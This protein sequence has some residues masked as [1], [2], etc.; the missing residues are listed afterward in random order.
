MSLPTARKWRPQNF[1]EVIGQDEVVKALKSAIALGKIGQAYLF[2]GPR[3]VGK[4]TIS[5]ILAKSLNC[6]NGP[7]IDPCNKCENCIEIKEGN[8]VDVIEI[9]GA[10]N[11]K[12]DDV[13]NIREAVKFAPVKS[14]YKIYII[15]EVHMLTDEAFNALLKTLEEPPSHVVFIFATTEPYKVK[16]TIRSR[17]QHFVLKP[18]SIDNIFKQLKKISQAEGYKLTD[19][20]LVRIAKAGN[21]SMRDAES[22]FDTVVSYL[23]KDVFDEEKIRNINEEDI[24]KILGII[25][26]SHIDLILNSI[27]N[28]DISQLIKIVNSLHSKGFDLKKLLEELIVSFRNLLLMKEFGTDKTIIKALDDEI[29]ILESIKDKFSKEDIIFIQN[30]L[31]KAYSE[32]RTSINELFHLENALFRIVNPENIITLSKLLEEVKELKN[33]IS[34]SSYFDLDKSIKDNISTSNNNKT[35]VNPLPPE[36]VKSKTKVERIDP[37]DNLKEELERITLSPEDIV[38]QIISYYFHGIRKKINVLVSEN[39]VKILMDKSTK[40]VLDKSLDDILTKIKSSLHTDN[41]ELH[42]IDNNSTQDHK[43][44]QKITKPTQSNSTE[45]NIISLF[46]AEEITSFT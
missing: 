38:K 41:V 12:I 2:S 11:R 45:K 34:S 28:K 20:I 29:K 42:V 9:D 10:S 14:R 46:N 30:T 7:T 22:V 31:I 37:A 6:V 32:M 25:D 44:Q 35:I 21:G 8:S 13:R 16:Q 40:G 23:G 17:C 19:S 43:P 27:A 15:D 26:I 24:S 18:L 3:G 39:S 1:D 36:S 4:T 33:L 5:R